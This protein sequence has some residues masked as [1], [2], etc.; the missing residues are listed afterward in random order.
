[1]PKNVDKD[2]DDEKKKKEEDKE[3]KVKFE[4]SCLLIEIIR[5]SWCLLHKI[6][7]Q[8]VKIY[9]RKAPQTS[10]CC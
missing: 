5:F 3:K 1:M 10:S 4:M 8:N 7:M 6:L 9:Y 2:F